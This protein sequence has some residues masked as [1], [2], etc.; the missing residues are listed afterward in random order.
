M[1]KGLINLNDMEK[2]DCTALETSEREKYLNW[3]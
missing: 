3:Y 1:L 2:S